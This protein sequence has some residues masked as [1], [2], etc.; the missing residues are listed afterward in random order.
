MTKYYNLTKALAQTLF[1]KNSPIIPD[2]AFPID[3]PIGMLL[4]QMRT[5]VG[6]KKI[7]EAENL[8]FDTI[9]KKVPPYLAVGIEFYARISELSEDELEAAD[10]SVEE[11]GEGIQD[12]LK[13][14]NIKMMHKSD[15]NAPKMNMQARPG[16]PMNG[17]GVPKVVM[18]RNAK[19]AVAPNVLADKPKA[20]LNVLADKPKGK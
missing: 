14:Y 9:D 6:E 17:V 16:V 5:L 18:N 19:P 15:P 10:F 20:P 13:F 11:I 1:R 8:I 3:N 12:L 7:N 2:D 4:A